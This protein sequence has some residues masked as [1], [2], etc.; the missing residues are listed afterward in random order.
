MRLSKNWLEWSVFAIGMVIVVT[1]VTILIRSAVQSGNTPP[2]L[3]VQ[4]GTPAHEQG[5]YRVPVVVENRGDITA[6]EASITIELRDGQTVVERAEI[7]FLFIPRRA[8]REGAVV[9][10]RNPS[11]C[12]LTVGAVGFETP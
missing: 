1:A 5:R 9:F 12:E 2:Q 8:K 7:A 4:L 11:C 6:A 3:A 10:T